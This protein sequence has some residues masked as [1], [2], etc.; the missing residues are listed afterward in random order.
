M[1]NNSFLQLSDKA[2]INLDQLFCC[3]FSKRKVCIL[4]ALLIFLKEIT[5]YIKVSF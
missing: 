3:M 2:Y 5:S 1:E 4:A